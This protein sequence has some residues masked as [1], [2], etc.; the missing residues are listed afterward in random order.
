MT[1][2][3]VADAALFLLSDLSRAISGEI[4]HAD[5]GAHAVAPVPAP[6]APPPVA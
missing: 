4:L 6:P 2:R 5:G 3:A 1:P